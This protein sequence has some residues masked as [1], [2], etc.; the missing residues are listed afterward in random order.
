MRFKTESCLIE[1]CLKR[2]L[3]AWAIFTGK[4]SGLISASIRN[5][6][7]KYGFTLSTQDIEDLKQ[8]ILVSIWQERKLEGLKNHSSLSYWLSIISGNAAMEYLRSMKREPAS[9]GRSIYDKIENSELHELIPSPV[10]N[11]EDIIFQKEFCERFEKAVEDLPVKDRLIIKLHLLHGK[12][13]EDIAD[14][15]GLP[16]GTVSSSVKRTKDKLKEKLRD[17]SK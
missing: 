11:T 6:A 3:A 17:F 12:I 5:R 14:M 9:K 10:K 1:S 8:E 4:Y 16:R 2:D 7:G 13:Y 15:L